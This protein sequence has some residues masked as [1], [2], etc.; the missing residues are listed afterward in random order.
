MS[1]SN[2]KI[3]LRLGIGFG[4]LLI[5][6]LIL[7]IV[8]LNGM[9]GLASLT[10]K[11][12][13]HPFT[14]S[15]AALRIDRNIS[16][17]R[18]SMRSAILADNATSRQRIYATINQ[19]DAA[20]DK[21]FAIILE[22]FL[23]DKGRIELTQ[24]TYDEWFTIIEREIDLLEN[25]QRNELEALIIGDAQKKLDELLVLTEEINGFAAN[26]AEEFHASAEAERVQTL[27]IMYGVAF[28]VL[29]FGAAFGFWTTRSI[30]T[31][32]RAAVQNLE[33]LADGDLAAT[34][35]GAQRQ[36]ETGQLL[37]AMQ[38]MSDTLVKVIG[39]VRTK[40]DNL[41]SAS[42]EVSATAQSMSQGAAEQAASVEE[43]SASLE[44]MT[45]SIAQNTENSKVTNRIASDS[46]R[47]AEEGGEAV[48]DTVS[49]MQQIAKKIGIIEEIA[50]KTNILALNAAIE[51]ARAG[52]HGRGFAVVAAEVQKLA[53]NSQGAAQEIGQLANSSVDIAEKAGTLLTTIV[54]NIRKTADLVQEITAAS[55]EQA[56][57]VD[58]VNK[59]V[60]QLDQISQQ[61]ASSAEELA[62]T[63]EEVSSQATHLQQLIEFFKL[64]YGIMDEA[65]NNARLQKSAQHVHHTAKQVHQTFQKNQSGNAVTSPPA[66]SPPVANNEQDFVEFDK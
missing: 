49:A 38:S 16:Q 4:S 62:A 42:E 9:T 50:Y 61:N 25:N 1:F 8:A 2:L 63:A 5:L 37:R 7:S 53:E 32:L 40:A 26:K 57:G 34:I 47:Q 59:A 44:Q 15:T 11:L 66:D 22:R 31:P 39:E 35:E 3:G 65:Q 24:K 23:G 12:Y 41:S 14:V 46:S 29:L 10:N 21:D 45:S 33:R 60:S 54:P 13:K 43:T 48:A 58:Q 36:D 20:T 52:E 64:P 30:T 51:A 27:N 56:S 19:Y 6:V 28:F 17:I 55:Q 18:L